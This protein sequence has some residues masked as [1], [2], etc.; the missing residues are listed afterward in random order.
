MNDPGYVPKADNVKKSIQGMREK[1]VNNQENDPLPDEVRRLAAQTCPGENTHF[2]GST[3]ITRKGVFGAEWLI[4]TD[5]HVLNVSISETKPAVLDTIEI[6]DVRSVEPLALVGKSVIEIATNAGIKRVISY[7]DAKTAAFAGAVDVVK[8]LKSGGPAQDA[9]SAPQETGKVCDVCGKKIPKDASRCP[10][11]SHKGRT[12]LRITDFSRPYA[13]LLALIL[14]FM[15]LSTGFGLIT[16]YLSK[17]FIDYILKPDPGTGIFAYAGWLPLAALLLFIAYAAQ[18]FL[19]GVQERFSGALGYKTVYDVRAAIYSRLQ[20]LSLSYFDKHQTGALLSR[21]N[22]DTGELQR[23][24]VDFFPLTL[25]SLLLLAGVGLFLLAL[26]WQLTLLICIPVLATV[27]FLKRIFPRVGLYFHRY[28]HRRSRL[29]ALVNDALSGI[30]VIKAFGR[31]TTEKEKFGRRSAAYRDAGVELIRTW[32]VYHPLLQFFIMC[33]GIIVWYAGGQL[34]FAGEMTVGSVVAYLGYLAMFYQPVLTLARLMEMLTTS[35]SAA[36]RVFDVID[37]QDGPADAPD[38]LAMPV[39]KGAVEFKNVTFGYDRLK[40]VIHDLSLSVRPCEKIGLVGKSGAGKSTIINLICRLYDADRGEILIDGVDVRRVRYADLRRQ[41]AVVLQDTFLFNGTIFDNIAYAKPEA[42][43]EKV[44]EAAMAANAHEFIIAKPDG[45]DTEVGERGGRLSG[46][47]KQRI[48][49]ARA[50]LRDP[51]ILILD[52]ATSLVDTQ[53]EHAIQQALDT[54]TNNRTTIA[55]AHRL[56]TLRNYHRLL[57]IDNGRLAEMGTHEELMQKKGAFYELVMLQQR[58]SQIVSG[59]KA[60][61]SDE[62][63]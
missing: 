53:T 36:E 29:S 11:C 24:I 1:P 48:A 37:A 39:I 23:F 60:E 61:A 30:R 58:L 3:D 18:V 33:G 44:I 45:Y 35:L 32:S 40:P 47:E 46:G 62:P 10:R 31:E 5:R 15:M 19:G 26:S 49:I 51:A 25:Q 8:R 54:L 6:S 13:G 52:E 14:L 2:A 16:P 43:R 22:Q 50:I 28:F 56:S 59:P 9:A 7:S 12:L 57:V 41:V 42:G 21:V 63:A 34:V 17:L 4:I 38:A 20:D 27:V 55:I